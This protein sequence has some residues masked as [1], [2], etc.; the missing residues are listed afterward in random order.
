MTSPRSVAVVLGTRPEIVKL[1]GVIQGLAGRCQVIYTG[2]HYDEELAAGIFRG[3]GLPTPDIR[4]T[5]IGGASRGYQVGAMICDLSRRFEQER[6]GAV[7]VQGDTNSTS[8]GAQAAHYQGIPVVHVEAGLRSR[9]RAMP[10]EINRQVVGVLADVHCAPTQQAADN[11]RSEG[12][13]PER[14]HLT[15]NTVVEAVSRS[16]PAPAVSLNLLRHYGQKPGAYVLATIHRPENT[17]DP[18]RLRRILRELAGLPL[19]VLFPAHPRTVRAC[20]R[21]GLVRELRALHPVPPVDHAAFLGL[22][23]HAALLVSDSGGIQ[24]ECTVLKKPLI[25]VRNSTERPEAVAAGFATLL[26]PGPQL[27]ATARRLLQDPGL[28]RRLAQLPSPYGDGR[29]SDRIVAFAT[30]LADRPVAAG[31][32]P[33]E[34]VPVASPLIPRFPAES[35]SPACTVLPQSAELSRPPV[36]A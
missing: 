34:A 24:E 16:L 1:A 23:Q 20:E 7:V 22:A 3:I 27:G 10:E 18:R 36:P 14:I 31:P 17:D 30:T 29:A 4:L 35:E 25:V 9:D 6:P 2:Q 8:A 28:H 33:V 21:F 19:P 5:G 12:V 32:P 15:G 11:L 13:A 26:P